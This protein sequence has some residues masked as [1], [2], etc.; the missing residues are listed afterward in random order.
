MNPRSLIGFVIVCATLAGPVRACGPFFAETMLDRPRAVL[1]PPITNF[2]MEARKLSSLVKTPVFPLPVGQSVFSFSHGTGNTGLDEECGELEEILSHLP[3]AKRKGQ[4]EQYR[5]LRLAMSDQRPLP[6]REGEALAKAQTGQWP[7]G[8]PD[9]VILYLKGALDYRDGNIEG[10][11][12]TWKELLQ[13]PPDQR[14]NRSAWAAWMIARATKESQGLAAAEEWY[15][16][17]EMLSA[18]GFRDCLGLGVSSI[19]WRAR[20]AMDR[21]DRRE[22]MVLYYGQ[23]MTG[24]PGAWTSLRWILPRLHEENA[25]E[26][27]KMAADPFQRG[28]ITASLLRSGFD[29]ERP[30]DHPYTDGL[31]WLEAV[32]AANV[33]DMSD[34]SR[35]AELA[36]TAGEFDVA[37]RWL[38]RSSATDATAWWI[39]G[40]IALMEGDTR[41]GEECLQKAE[42]GFPRELGEDAPIYLDFGLAASLPP[43]LANAYRT[44][45]FY[46]DLGV[47]RIALAQYAGGLTALLKGCWQSD[48][49][50]V[51]ERVLT[52]GELLDYVRNYFPGDSTRESGDMDRSHLEGM[53]RH[54][55]ARRFAREGYFNEARGLFPGK[56]VPIFDQYVTQRRRGGRNLFL[57]ADERARSLWRAAQ[58]HRRFGMELFGTEEEPDFAEAR[59]GFLAFPF[60]ENRF[61]WKFPYTQYERYYQEEDAPPFVPPPSR[62]EER[63]VKA[64]RLSHEER[65]QYRYVAADLAWDAASLMPDNSDETA[66]VLG[67]AGS[68]LKDRNPAAADRFYKAMIWRNWSTPLAREADARRWFPYIPW[69][70]EPAVRAPDVP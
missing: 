44:S 16:L 1:R 24:D 66:R 52:R 53:M 5:D 6:A 2:E 32:E 31:R 29:W 25:S 50:Y 41:L 48:A 20:A 30:P 55:A 64:H 63:R 54:L 69:D 70:F 33:T 9:D 45:Q 51:A 17:C 11:I 68:W 37:K 26:L 35:L 61:G 23:G 42:A 62:D 38:N 14:R 60:L 27:A 47:A 67:I 4:I 3:E 18:E 39:R 59:G 19:G 46:G 34:A 22:A 58:I 8:W 40:K 36:Y 7:D 28:L 56:Y 12:R 10:A 13:L 57:T 49:A 65:F 43:D 15:Q 21:G